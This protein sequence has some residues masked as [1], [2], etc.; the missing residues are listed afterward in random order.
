MLESIFRA[1]I[2]TLANGRP[3]GIGDLHALMLSHLED[4][5]PYIAATNV[6]VFKRFWNEDSRGRVTSP[7]GEE[8]KSTG[9]SPSPSLSP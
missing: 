6:D 2:A 7:K 9:F 5:G 4:L 3:A 1:A 8:L